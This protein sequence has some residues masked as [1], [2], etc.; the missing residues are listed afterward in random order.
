MA[1][2]DNPAHE[3]AQD[4]PTPS[5]ELKRTLGPPPHESP[6]TTE[7][8]HSKRRPLSKKIEQEKKKRKVAQRRLLQARVNLVAKLGKKRAKKKKLTSPA[9]HSSQVDR[10]QAKVQERQT[11]R[12]FFAMKSRRLSPSHEETVVIR[13][14]SAGEWD[15]WCYDQG[16]L[17]CK[18]REALIKSAQKYFDYVLTEYS[19]FSNIYQ[20]EHLDGPGEQDCFDQ[21]NI[22]SC[23]EM[24][25]HQLIDQ[26]R[27]RRAQRLEFQKHDL[28][29]R[30][31]L[32]LLN[33]LIINCKNEISSCIHKAV[34]NTVKIRRKLKERHWKHKARKSRRYVDSSQNPGLADGRPSPLRVVTNIEDLKE[35]APTDTKVTEKVSGDIWGSGEEGAQREFKPTWAEDDASLEW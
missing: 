21:D 14:R 9:Q 24:V 29:A 11:F 2:V 16:S 7:A 23:T 1:V 31:F 33:N 6:A 17:F 34:L 28:D 22:D 12:L 4:V 35:E 27:L 32:C 26:G 5:A 20:W 25:R 10:R 8:Q 15:L 13:S 3:A 19:R 18:R 30:D